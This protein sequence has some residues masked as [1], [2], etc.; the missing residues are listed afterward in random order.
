MNDRW[1]THTAIE[2]LTQATAIDPGYANAWARLATA[3]CDMHFFFDP[4]AH[5]H[6]RAKE[7]VQRA[8]ALDPYGAEAHLAHSS[9]SWS[10]DEGFQNDAALRSLARSLELRHGAH[11]ALL[12]KGL[13]LSHVGLLD[14]A[15]QYLAAAIAAEPDDPT[16]LGAVA[17]TFSYQG[18]YESALDHLSRVLERA[19]GSFMAHGIYGA[20]WLYMDELERARRRTSARSAII[21]TPNTMP[22][23]RTPCWAAATRRS[24]SC[25]SLV[26]PGCRTIRFSPRIRTLPRFARR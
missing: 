4:A 24:S 18:R 21:T 17:Q 5:W 14:E 7:A 12:W 22:R 25:G 3:C 16:T 20:L 13:I 26:T 19:P 6:T 11:R 8:F 23:R 1:Q 15:Q 10:P 9:I 2:M